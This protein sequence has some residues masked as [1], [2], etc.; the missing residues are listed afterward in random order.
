MAVLGLQVQDAQFQSEVNEATW[1]SDLKQ[2]RG[3]EMPEDSERGDIKIGTVEHHY[4]QDEKSEDASESPR[5][6]L[7]S[8]ATKLAL[9][10]VIASATGGAGGFLL[11]DWFRDGGKDVI[12]GGAGVVEET[13]RQLRVTME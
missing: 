11:S 12:E 8:G 4:H 7:M 2:T 13:K 6:Q 1:R 3:I 5:K 10:A 9:A